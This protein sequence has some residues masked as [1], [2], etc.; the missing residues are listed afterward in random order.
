MI[1]NSLRMLTIYLQCCMEIIRSWRDIYWECLLTE[2]T[3]LDV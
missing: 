3:E 2:G 1:E